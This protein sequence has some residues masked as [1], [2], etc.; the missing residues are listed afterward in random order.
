MNCF[1]LK[2]ET[3]TNQISIRGTSL[4]LVA[5]GTVQCLPA[6]SGPDAM[7]SMHCQ[8]LQMREASTGEYASQTVCQ[9]RRFN[10]LRRVISVV[11]LLPR[12]PSALQSRA[13]GH[14]GLL[15]LPHRP[16]PLFFQEARQ[17]RTTMDLGTSV[18]APKIQTLR[19]V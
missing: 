16:S 6:R 1:D 7:D 12:L 18:L 14:V 15:P 2:E 8:Q 10:F 9:Q 17:L 19:Y 4:M 5:M 11:L 3:S 13:D